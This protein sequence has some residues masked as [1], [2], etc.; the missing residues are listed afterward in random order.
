MGG[1]EASPG[2]HRKIHS[3]RWA[4]PGA[5]PPPSLRSPGADITPQVHTAPVCLPTHT[6]SACRVHMPVPVRRYIHVDSCPTDRPTL[7][8]PIYLRPDAQPPARLHTASR[9]SIR[10]CRTRAGPSVCASHGP[11][12]PC[13]CARDKLSAFIYSPLHLG[14]FTALGPAPGAPHL[15]H[16]GR[17]RGPTCGDH[18]DAPVRPHP[19]PC[20]G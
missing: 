10:V 1:G 14:V 4:P 11:R 15:G 18:S 2:I 9:R 19:P 3:P 12:T 7:P 13:A 16:H 8:H 5:S 20:A 6:A 17:G